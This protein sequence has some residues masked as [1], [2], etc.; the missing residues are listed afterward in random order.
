[1]TSGKK[2][3]DDHVG[4]EL[5]TSRVYAAN[6][7]SAGA[8]WARV[9]PTQ[10]RSPLRDPTQQHVGRKSRKVPCGR[11]GCPL[12]PYKRKSLKGKPII[13]GPV[14]RA[15]ITSGSRH[16]KTSLEFMCYVY[17][18]YIHIYIYIYIYTYV[19]IYIY[20]YIYVFMYTYIHTC[21]YIYIYIERERET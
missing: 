13:H 12:I 16:D 3:L 1:M 19:Y 8:R 15:A 10:R 14:R 18:V 2:K 11:V 9:S 6:E 17:C 5:E 20:I 21:V 4:A 7:S